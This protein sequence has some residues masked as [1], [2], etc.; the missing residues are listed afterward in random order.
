MHHD[1]KSINV[2]VT[3]PLLLNYVADFVW[4]HRWDSNPPGTDRQSVALPEDYYGKTWS[5][6]RVTIPSS[7]LERVMTSPEVECDIKLVETTGF[8]PRTRTFTELEL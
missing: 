2:M 1:S 5:R 6:I 3:I 4:R 7:H 8:E